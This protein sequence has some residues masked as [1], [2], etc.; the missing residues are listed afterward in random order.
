MTIEP[1]PEATRQYFL[2]TDRV[3]R[4]LEEVGY[5]LAYI[6]HGECPLCGNPG[7][8]FAVHNIRTSNQDVLKGPYRCASCVSD[9]WGSF[10]RGIT[11]SG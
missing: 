2:T 5:D 7:A 4:Q 1:L 6:G 8:I 10:E 9:W 3:N 11:G